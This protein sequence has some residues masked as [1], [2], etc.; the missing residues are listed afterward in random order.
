MGGIYPT[1]RVM[2]PDCGRSKIQFPTQSKADN[3]IK[4]NGD[5]LVSEGETLRSYYCPS[6]CAWHITRNKERKVKNPSTPTDRLISAY[7]RSLNYKKKSIVTE[8]LVKAG[9]YKDI[10]DTIVDE[11]LKKDGDIGRKKINSFV[12]KYLNANGIFTL[13]DGVTKLD[14]SALYGP[15]YDE[16]KKIK[17]KEII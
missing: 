12:T 16:Y 10:I 3:F 11:L 15:V 8:K 13:S 9:A 7:H 2:C 6:C 17:S 1:H 5:E 4:W 14:R